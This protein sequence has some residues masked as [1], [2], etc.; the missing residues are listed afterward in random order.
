MKNQREAPVYPMLQAQF[1]RLICSE[2]DYDPYRITAQILTAM[3]SN[4]RCFQ[5]VTVENDAVFH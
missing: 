4:L 5:R 1:F 2:P 3:R